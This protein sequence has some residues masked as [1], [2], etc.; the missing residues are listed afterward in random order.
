MA[1][2]NSNA[3]SSS[4]FLTSCVQLSVAAIKIIGMK[5]ESYCGNHKWN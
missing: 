4:T 3:E 2:L 1:C 5:Q